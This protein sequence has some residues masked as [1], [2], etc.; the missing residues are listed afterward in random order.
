MPADKLDL[1]KAH[2][3]QYKATAKPRIVELPP[4]HYLVVEAEGSPTD[5]R[6]MEVMG[7]LYGIAYTLKFM[8]KNKGQDFV[9]S[10]LEGMWFPEGGFD[11]KIENPSE[12]NWKYK[13]MIRM[14]E[15]V[16]QDD[17]PTAREQL[18]KK[19]KEGPF[20]LVNLSIIEEG[21]VVQ[22]LHIGPYAE[23]TPTLE[24]MHTWAG[25]QGY[26][27]LPNHHE[28][29]LSDPRRGDP[30]K[31]RTILRTPVEKM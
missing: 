15:F 2:K 21:T 16:R 27:H 9:V 30:A 23:E 28:I 5:D 8:Y 18:E 13:L 24:A 17:L 6:F 11:Q 26:K 14:P 12:M 22:A 19:K 31:L 4:I 7:A 10:K 3:D 25:E 1:Y 29:Y 20:D